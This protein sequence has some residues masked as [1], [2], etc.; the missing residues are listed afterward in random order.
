MVCMASSIQ[1]GLYGNAKYVAC[2]CHKLHTGTASAKLDKE[3]EENVET[4]DVRISKEVKRE[5]NKQILMLKQ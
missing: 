4:R 2:A 5:Q 1:Y 3:T